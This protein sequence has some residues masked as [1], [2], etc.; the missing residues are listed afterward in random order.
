MVS[1][2]ELVE[3]AERVLSEATRHGKKL[4]RKKRKVFK[5]GQKSRRRSG[6]TFVK[7]ADGWRRVAKNPR[8]A[9]AAAGDGG[10]GLS[11]LTKAVRGFL[12]TFQSAKQAAY[13]KYAPAPKP[14]STDPGDL[15]GR[16]LKRKTK[17]TRSSRLKRKRGS[18]PSE[19]ARWPAPK[20][21]G[22]R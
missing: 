14:K 18:R 9:R 5:V 13:S 3:R 8:R 4:H 2:E 16:P 1:I 10:S 15:F 20:K 19:P 22:P 7:T 17:K 21:P 6:V 12:S 11:D